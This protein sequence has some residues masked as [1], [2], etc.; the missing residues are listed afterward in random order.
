MRTIIL[1]F[2]CSLGL[3]SYSQERQQMDMKAINLPNRFLND[4]DKRASSLEQ[5]M[6][7]RSERYI[8]KFLSQE[9]KLKKV[10]SKMDSNAAK[11]LFLSNPEGKY[12]SYLKAFRTK[13]AG[14]NKIGGE[15][16]AY[17]DSLQGS[18]KFLKAH[19]ANL[20]TGVTG[21]QLEGTLAS[22]QQLQ[23]KIN[24]GNE[25]GQYITERKE[26]IKQFLSLQTKVPGSMQQL[27]SNYNKQLYYY[28]AQ[29]Q[30]YKGMLNDPDKIMLNALR[31]LNKVPAFAGFMKNN[32]YLSGLMPE[33]NNNTI[34]TSIYGMQTR[35][36]ISDLVQRQITGGGSGAGSA[37]SDGIQQA[38]SKLDGLKDKLASFGGGAA[39]T[40]LPANFKPNNQKTKTFGQR[41]EYGLD[42]QTT[43]S[44]AYFPVST[45]FGLSLGYKLN[46]KST[47]GIGVSYRV[48]WG[49]DIR[50]MQL[51]G[52]GLGLRSF[53]DWTIKGGLYAS[54]GF[55]YNYQ[56]LAVSWNKLNQWSNWRSGG[57]IGIGKELAFK[58]RFFKKTNVQLLWDFLSYQQVPRTQAFKL[59]IG[60]KF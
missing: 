41:L 59:R 3:A 20:P 43:G 53:F 13:A 23:G 54:G 21:K 40:D 5:E 19:P 8:Q 18:L 12:M 24:V 6:D 38:Q 45:D 10:F 11:M 28:S 47:V 30:A 4:I 27:Y 42:I 36:G 26:Q 17:A 39:S 49:Q 48:G 14:S 50:H 33:S 34:G 37:F 15:Y 9:K 58:N 46:N 44:T 2:F 57:L 56:P 55:E 35:D 29:L 1:V 25:L 32:S 22:V 16:I 52:Q 51:T 60:Y 7:K 31:V